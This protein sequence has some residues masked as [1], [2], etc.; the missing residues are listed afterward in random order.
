LKLAVELSIR[1]VK[2]EFDLQMSESKLEQAF[3]RANLN[4]NGAAPS[5]ETPVCD[6]PPA[7]SASADS[8]EIAAAAESP[9]NPPVGDLSRNA[10]DKGAV[11]VVNHAAV[12][13]CDL[14]FTPK[15]DPQKPLSNPDRP[16]TK[17]EIKRQQKQRERARVALMNRVNSQ[18]RK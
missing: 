2:F 3:G 1:L 12:M 16:L 5:V 4:E 9:S 8:S 15:Q 10:V 11:Q 18:K 6:T 14:D 7:T 13:D 17:K